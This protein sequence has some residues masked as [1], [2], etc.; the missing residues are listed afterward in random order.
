[1]VVSKISDAACMSSLTIDIIF[2]REGIFLWKLSPNI[3]RI[4]CIFGGTR[5]VFVHLLIGTEA[6]LI[7]GYRLCS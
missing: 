1:M 4:P 6:S 3:H 7:S 2:M 5:V